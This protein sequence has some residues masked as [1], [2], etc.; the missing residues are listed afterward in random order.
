LIEQAVAAI[1]KSRSVVVTSHV[2]PDGDALG[3][4]LGMLRALKALG[5][6]ARAISPSHVPYGFTFMLER[7][8]EVVRYDPVRDDPVLEAAD[9]FL[10]LD[11]ASLD[12]AG[13]VGE[14]MAELGNPTLMIDHH[15][16]N[17]ALGTWNYIIHDA[18]STAALCVN[19]LDGLGVPLTLPLAVPLYIGIITDTGNFNYPSTTPATHE[20]A[21][22]LL[23]AGVNPYEI[24]RQLA[25]DRTI[26]FIR[27]A[28]LAIFNVQ[29][30]RGGEI[31]YSVVGHELY[32]RFRAR[33]DELV[34]LPPY[35]I[36]IRNVEV[37]ALFLEY[38][39]GKIL[40]ELRSQGLIN[41]GTLAKNLGGGGHSG[42]ADVRIEGEMADIVQQIV[43]DASVRLDLAHAKGDEDE[44]RSRIWRRV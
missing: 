24:H 44:R 16:T 41:V 22:R 27:L 25:L 23:A 15:T 26:D 28:G 30:A 29:F 18:S 19:V 39:P 13:E 4:T 37:G 3:S 14:K 12:R 5:K 6:E 7:E 20:K 40:I 1:R 31:A 38:E 34:M 10:V 33:V 21:A 8:D 32:R 35:L 9:L 11:C 42:A 43:Q 17:E 36:S 2:Q